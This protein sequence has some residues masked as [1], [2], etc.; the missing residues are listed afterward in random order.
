MNSVYR[1]FPHK[2][3]CLSLPFVG[4]YGAVRCVC[5][6]DDYIVS[7]SYDCT[8]R[9][10]SASDGECLHILHHH[11]DRV[12]T[13]LF[14][15]TRIISGSLDTTMRVWNLDTEELEHTFI[16]HQSLTSE[17][18]LDE[19]R[20]TVISSNADETIRIWSLMSGKC[21]HI[22]AGKYAVCNK[23]SPFVTYRLS[24]LS[25][26][27]G[28]HKHQS[29]VTCVQLV[30]DFIISSGDDGIVKLWD[31][32]TGAFIRDIVRLENIGS[33]VWRIV[34][35]DD[36]RFLICAVGS[37]FGSQQP[38]ELIIINFQDLNGD[39]VC[40][41]QNLPSRTNFWD[42]MLIPQALEQPPLELLPLPLPLPPPP[43]TTATTGRINRRLSPSP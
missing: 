13:L 36:A 31:R 2:Q 8:V 5:F 7:G 24:F 3:H 23:P 18:L 9:V 12:Y 43:T 21:Q 41:R 35:T 6:V 16:G 11:A 30:K 28:V 17:M 14:D 27:L 20:G 39:H 33:V 1:D 10:W 15:G 37:R 22:L 26:L 40:R 42:A 38:T 4:H 25:I 32:E 34:A 29:A 19:S